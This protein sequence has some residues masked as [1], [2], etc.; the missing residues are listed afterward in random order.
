[1]LWGKKINLKINNTSLVLEN[2][3]D[4]EN[5]LYLLKNAEI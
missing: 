4:E 5:K 1:M 2:Y 3:D